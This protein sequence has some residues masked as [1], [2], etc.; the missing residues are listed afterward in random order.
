MDIPSIEDLGDYKPFVIYMSNKVKKRCPSVDLQDLIGE[1]WLWVVIAQ[2]NYNPD[3]GSSFV[4]YLY[5]IL[6][7]RLLNYCKKEIKH[8]QY[9]SQLQPNLDIHHDIDMDMFMDVERCQ[10]ETGLEGVKLFKECK[11]RELI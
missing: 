10:R 8:H 9:K 4:T 6:E 5:Y 1:A 11:R 7:S 3:K 2:G